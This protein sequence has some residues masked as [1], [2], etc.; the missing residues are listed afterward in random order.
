MTGAQYKILLRINK[1][2]TATNV[3]IT[4]CRQAVHQKHKDFLATSAADKNSLL[5]GS[6]E[7][8]VENDSKTCPGAG[9]YSTVLKLTGCSEEEFT[10]D[11][12]SC[13]PMTNRCNAKKDCA[14]GTDEA[15]CKTFVRA[16]GYNRFITPPPVGNDTRPKMFLSITIDEIVEINEKDGFFRCQ[17]W[18]ER[19]WIDRRLTFQNLKKESELNE[20][21]PEDRD[22]IWKPWTA[23]KNIEDRSKYAR[24]DLKQVWKVVPNSNFSFERADTSVLSNTYFFDGASN[25]ISYEIGYT[26]EWLCDFHM[27]WYPF[28]SQSCTMKFLQQED[29]LVLVPETVKYI[30][31]DLEQH[32][33]RTHCLSGV[34]RFKKK[35]HSKLQ[36][37]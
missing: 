8:K 19:K 15:E 29:S 3:S 20:I 25:M 24:T 10:C 30:G 7:W 26:T 16:I 32:F 35:V 34:P 18:M 4:L 21:N 31:G 9:S 2:S 6:H 14:D 5:I 27:A 11:D 28:D 13:V 12:G 37:P 1:T 33:I 36:S 17:V 23:Y 22:L